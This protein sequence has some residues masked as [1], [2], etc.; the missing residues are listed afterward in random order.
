MDN[1]GRRSLLLL[2]LSLLFF[3]IP[4]LFWR[5]VWFGR[6]L[7]AAEIDSYLSADK[8]R[9]VQHA[10][11][12][13]AER[14]IRGDIQPRD[15]AR[16]YPRIAAMA[17]HHVTEIRR[18]AAWVMGQDNNSQEFHQALAF[19]LQDAEP[20]VRQNAALALAR[21]GDPSAHEEILAMLRPCIVRSPGAGVLSFSLA[22]RDA[23]TPGTLL[24]RMKAAARESIE[25]R[26]PLPGRVCK[27]LAADG[28]RVTSGEPIVLISP[29]PAQ[30]WEALRALVLIGRPE[31]LPQVETLARSSDEESGITPNIRQQAVLTAQA[32]RR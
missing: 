24:A 8:S 29:A 20:I 10:M 14:I 2:L 31:D 30:V 32:I 9:L 21:F 18:D 15:A 12:Q 3:L 27:R 7:D 23:V 5:A 28:Q 6:R 25:I 11:A 22:E 19:L 4:F 1:K 13:V 26:S 17:N 16:W